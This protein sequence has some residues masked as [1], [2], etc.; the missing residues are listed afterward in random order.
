VTP[1]LT[2]DLDR[3]RSR[4]QE[5]LLDAFDPQSLHYAV[6]CNSHPAVLQTIR[7]AGGCFEVASTGELNLLNGLGFDIDRV[8]FSAPVRSTTQISEAHRIGL[9]RFVADSY[10]E[11]DRLADSAPGSEVLV[12][13]AAESTG[14]R[15]PRPSGDPLA[16]PRIVTPLRKGEETLS[17][18]AGSTC[19]ADDR[20]GPDVYLPGG[21][22]VGDQI[23][24]T[25]AGAYALSYQTNF[26]GFTQLHTD[27][28]FNTAPSI[29]RDD[30]LFD[31]CQ[32]GTELFDYAKAVESEL[33]ES[34]ADSHALV[35]PGDLGAWD[36]DTVLAVVRSG[37]EVICAA[38]EIWCCE[39]SARTGST[40]KRPTIWPTG[41]ALLESIG[42]EHFVHLAAVS[43]R[44]HPQALDAV[45]VCYS[46]CATASLASGRTHWLVPSRASFLETFRGHWGGAPVTPLGPTEPEPHALTAAAAFA[47]GPAV[48][49]ARERN[50]PLGRLIA[51]GAFGPPARPRPRPGAV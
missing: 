15:W 45:A 49:T 46:A 2:M 35:A 7:D 8:I 1:Y 38:R 21:L 4:V 9:L 20:I 17:T 39:T 13:L 26:C 5:E 34:N 6:K 50:T 11:L 41:Q 31:R 47:L 48:D 28:R 12:R 14:S 30:L 36:A 51:A 19:D 24:F 18:L 27:L 3:V 23:T 43:S 25:E 42:T 22:Q 44:P 40:S 16:L 32:P 37:E 10:Q 29:A 33:G